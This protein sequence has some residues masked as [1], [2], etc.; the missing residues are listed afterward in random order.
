MWKG[1]GAGGGRRRGSVGEGGRGSLCERV[2]EGL[3]DDVVEDIGYG[4]NVRRR[5]SRLRFSDQA[6]LPRHKLATDE[7][8]HVSPASLFLLVL[9]MHMIHHNGRRDALGSWLD[10]T[11]M[12]RG[13]RDGVAICPP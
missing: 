9:E 10:L 12:E 13:I 8:M 3:R 11:H 7:C 2:R 1:E 4:G 6:D 5:L